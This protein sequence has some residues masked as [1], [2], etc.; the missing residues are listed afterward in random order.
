MLLFTTDQESSTSLHRKALA[1]LAES[2]EDE[3][4]CHQVEELTALF[5]T[6]D[7]DKAHE[8]LVPE[9]D[10]CK[11]EKCLLLSLLRA[12]IF[13]EKSLIRRA[14][15]EYKVALTLRDE[16]GP[17]YYG[18]FAIEPVLAS[19]LLEEEAFS[20]AI[21]YLRPWVE[22]Y[23]ENNGGDYYHN[24]GIAYLHLKKFDSSAF[25]FEKSI[26]IEMEM[27]DTLGL[28]ISY[29]DM[30]NLYYEQYLDDQAIPYFQKG[31][32]YALLA[33]DPA[34]LRNAY[35]NMAVV[36]ENRGDL[37]KALGYRKEYEQVQAT[38][39]SRDKVWEMAEKEKAY[40]VG[41]REREITIL[42][43][44]EQVKNAELSRQRWQI[45]AYLLASVLLLILVGVV[46]AGY[47]MVSRSN[48]QMA[49]QKRVLEQMDTAKNRL[50]SIV[51]HDLKAP[52]RSL[53]RSQ[54]KMA[55]AA[56]ARDKETLFALATEN[57]TLLNAT[58]NLLNNLLQWSLDQT[59][60][61]HL[62]RESIVAGRLIGQVLYDYEPMFR[63]RGIELVTDFSADAVVS[64]D[65]QSMKIVLRNLLDN[66]LKFTPPG[67]RVSISTAMQEDEVI[68]ALED[69]GCGM[70]PEVLSQLFEVSQEK[71]Q[72]GTDGTTGTGLGMILCRA[73]VSRN[74]GSI[75]VES[76][77]GQKTIV[78][79]KLPRAKEA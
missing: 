36:E 33:Q 54:Q 28:A 60:Q 40:E 52:V 72:A 57:G 13:Y 10:Q 59:N 63:E 74:G 18:A 30:A 61:V 39:W 69:N 11:G 12:K 75:E 27:S 71:I 76:Q 15:E 31:L 46:A 79:L 58:Q 24:L 48:K 43:Q 23:S 42:E 44:Q 68:I 3:S 8:I 7:F 32:D 16:L 37:K 34:V 20:T 14:I 5:Q 22:R 45:K 53:Q 73:F 21:H 38:L 2:C 56:S 62:V 35:L 17:P 47:R 4:T 55:A 66:A 29:M 41:I 6:G 64:V 25:Y 67:G 51:A 70:G 65:I 9:Y 50:F 1:Y 49:A 26:G 77:V 19:L 78:T